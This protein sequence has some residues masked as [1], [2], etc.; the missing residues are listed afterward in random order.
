MAFSTWKTTQYLQG[1]DHEGPIFPVL[2]AGV[3]FL[4]HERLEVRPD[5]VLPLVQPLLAVLAGQQHRSL[6]GSGLVVA[7]VVEGGGVGRLVVAVA[8]PLGAGGVRGTGGR[9]TATSLE[10]R[11]QGAGRLGEG[12]T[13]DI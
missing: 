4:G 5:L 3:F 7:V 11:E 12:G 9:V 13:L 2:P 10:L 1:S 6:P 8:L